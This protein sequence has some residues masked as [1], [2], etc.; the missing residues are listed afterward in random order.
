MKVRLLAV[1]VLV[2]TMLVGAGPAQSITSGQLDNGTHPYVGYAR[3]LQFSCSATAITPTLVVTAAHCFTFPTD[4]A[5]VNFDDNYRTNPFPSSSFHKG[6]WHADP[7]FCIACKP[8]L[9]GF[10]THDIAVI[11]LDEPLYLPSYGALPSAELVDRLGKGTEITSVGY[12][13]QELIPSQ[14]GKVRF[15]D[16]NRMWASSTIVSDNQRTSDEFLKLAAKPVDDGGGT[17][18]GDSGGPNFL[19]GTNVMLGV[20]SYVTNGNCA[21]VTYSY[22]TDTDAAR[23]FLSSWGVPLG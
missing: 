7:Q 22:R 11:V 10:D 3:N 21:G 12:G 17:C 5:W 6:T 8:G 13:V 4:T 20:N 15:R 14:G 23:A 16:G 2:L 19:A 1:A 9:V 18:F